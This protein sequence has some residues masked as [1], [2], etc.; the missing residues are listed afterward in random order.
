MTTAAILGKRVPDL[1]LVLDSEPGRNPELRV[2]CEIE[3][4]E[5]EANELYTALYDPNGKRDVTKAHKKIKG[6]LGSQTKAFKDII[7]LAFK[8]N[9]ST[10]P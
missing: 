5:T 8:D 9:G 10:E 1:V 2:Q 7:D 6:K 4:T 3:L